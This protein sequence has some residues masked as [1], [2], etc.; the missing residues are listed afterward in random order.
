MMTVRGYADL[1]IPWRDM[2]KMGILCLRV[3]SSRQEC[4]QEYMA[5]VI[6]IFLNINHKHWARG[7]GVGELEPGVGGLGENWV[8]A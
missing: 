3:A 4:R 2:H 8:S 1:L 7:E 5:E 6:S